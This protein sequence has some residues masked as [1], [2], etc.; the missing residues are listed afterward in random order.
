MADSKEYQGSLKPMTSDYSI[1]QP[2]TVLDNSDEKRK[3][4][5]S[6]TKR[7]KEFKSF[8]DGRVDSY[9]Q[10]L[11]GGN[12]AVRKSDDNWIVAE[13]II[14]ELEIWKHFIEDGDI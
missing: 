9:K 1:E 7:W 14:N 13:C 6:R 8:A 5:I 4:S 10:F 3:K 11:P 12:P 2:E